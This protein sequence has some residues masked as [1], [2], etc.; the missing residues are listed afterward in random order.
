M[1]Q[2]LDRLDQCHPIVRT[3]AMLWLQ[4]CT[5]Q[6]GVDILIVHG[7]RPVR[8]Q[9]LIYQQG[10]EYDRAT[11]DWN[12]VDPTKVITHSKP[13][14][15]GHNVV[16]KETGK[17]ASLCVDIIPSD[18]KGVIL[19]KQPNETDIQLSHRWI[20]TFDCLD[21]VAWSRLYELSHKYGLDP[22]G[23]KVGAY[24]AYDKGHFEEPGWRYI[25]NDLGLAFPVSLTQNIT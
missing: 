12:V 6:F 7:Y 25:M 14:R 13:G 8:D 15:S 3:K 17:G 21:D 16:Y 24:L 9:L 22:L 10:R 19:W 2:R 4:A 18:K 1:V 23:D 5:T 11:G 20:N